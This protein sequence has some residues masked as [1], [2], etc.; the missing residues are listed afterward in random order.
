MR[1]NRLEAFSDGVL[2]IV[3][4]IMVLE[5]KAPDKLTMEELLGD[6]PVLMSYLLSFVMVAIVWVN[7][8]HV[9]QLA[10]HV[11]ARVLWLNNHLLLWVSLTPFVTAVVGKNS[12]VPLAAALYGGVMFGSALAF[13]LLRRA[14]AAL[15]AD[16][17]HVARLHRRAHVR[18][19]IGIGAYLVSIPLAYLSPKLSYAIFVAVALMYFLP[20]AGTGQAK[21]VRTARPGRS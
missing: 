18:N 2:A 8:H 17:A 1:T 19:A 20:E 16:A 10:E 21:A 7:H 5:L 4:T 11:D 3:I 6:M 9:F 15:G 14:I 12:D 13:A